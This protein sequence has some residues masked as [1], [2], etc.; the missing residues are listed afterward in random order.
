[1]IKTNALAGN[2]EPLIQYL[3]IHRR[4]EEDQANDTKRLVDVIDEN[5]D[6]NNT[7]VDINDENYDSNSPFVNTKIEVEKSDLTDLGVFQPLDLRISYK[8]SDL[9]AIEVI[10]TLDKPNS[11]NYYIQRIFPSASGDLILYRSFTNFDWV[12]LDDNNF[13]F[14]SLAGDLERYLYDDDRNRII[15][16]T[17]L[18]SAFAYADVFTY[19]PKDVGISSGRYIIKYINHFGKETKVT[20]RDFHPEEF[21][22]KKIPKNYTNRNIDVEII[23]TKGNVYL[24]P[25]IRKRAGTFVLEYKYV[26]DEFLRFDMKFQKAAV[27]LEFKYLGTFLYF[28]NR[29]IFYSNSFENLDTTDSLDMYEL[30]NQ[31]MRTIN[32]D[33]NISLHNGGIRQLFIDQYIKCVSEEFSFYKNNLEKTLELF[34]YAPTVFI[35]HIHLETLWKVLDKSLKGRIT[36]FGLNKEDVTLKLLNAILEKIRSPKLFLD[37]LLIRRDTNNVSYF[38][39]LFSKMH[40]SNFDKYVR[41]LWSVWKQTVYKDITEKNTKIS[42]LCEPYL[43][44]KS[45]KTI[46]FH[47]DNAKIEYLTASDEVQIDLTYKI[48]KQVK[49]KIDRNTETTIPFRTSKEERLLYDPYAPIY[50]F[51]EDNPH[52]IFKDSEDNKNSYFAVLPAFVMLAREERAFWSN[53]ITAGEYAIDIL[54]TASGF[55][56]IAKA[57][58]L[59]KILNAGHKLIGRTKQATQFIAGAKRFAGYI[60]ITSGIGNGLIKLLGYKDTTLGNTIAKYLFFLEMLSLSGELSAALH[61]SLSKTAREIVTHPEFPNIKKQAE[62]IVKK[63]DHTGATK[64]SKEIVEAEEAL[65]TSRHLEEITEGRE[66]FR[67]IEEL[68]DLS[69][70]RLLNKKQLDL[71]KDF[72]FQKYKVRLRLVDVDH[73]LKTKK[74]ILRNGKRISKLED[75]DNRRVLGSFNQGPPPQLFLRSENA[76]ELTVFHEIVHLK[77]WFNK[78]PKVHYAQEEIVVWNE[79]WKT[80]SRWTQKELYDSY[81]YVQDLVVEAN[82]KG[83][84]IKFDI[85][86]EMEGLKYIYR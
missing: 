16:N 18:K 10:D 33:A 49:V 42:D 76:S 8:S 29:T 60:E 79:I 82:R 22:H 28:I 19:N 44:Y 77:Y 17:T 35:K 75:W 62:E 74:T 63:G 31:I 32:P 9:L 5:F 21:E 41:F 67:K 30:M 12:P 52:F 80:K 84:K 61:A 58:R 25:T 56:N 69:G 72:L 53:V 40:T 45:D 78:M 2:I 86:N 51:N 65:E 46:G 4:L 27:T 39:N 70:G 23:Q 81:K 66:L 64:K 43:N 55:L 15:Y 57:G 11:I 7:F 26:L 47:H 68:F 6:Y 34:F 37:E 3:Q 14:I 38:Y 48:T 83:A 24:F 54:T 20:R 13:T 59:Y 73:T 50:I 71:F 85:N 1:M 36:N